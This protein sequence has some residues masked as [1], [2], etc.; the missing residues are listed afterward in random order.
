MVKHENIPIYYEKC[1]NIS[2]PS[3]PFFIDKMSKIQ[4]LSEKVYPKKSEIYKIYLQS[5]ILNK[6]CHDC[7]IKKFYKL[8]NIVWA[9][10]IKHNIETHQSY[11]SE[12]FIKIILNT[13]I[14]NNYII[15]PPIQIHSNQINTFKY[16][17]LH[18][19]KLLI[20]DALMK[21]GSYPRYLIQKNTK[22]SE[23]QLEINSDS[24]GINSNS[25][26]SFKQMDIR[27]I[28]SEHSGV[29]SVKNGIIDNIIV[30]TKTDRID[31]EDNN[32]YLPI[33]T[34][35]LI[36]YEYLFHT[37]PNT[38]RYAG[39]IKEGIIYEFPSVNDIFNFIKYRTEGKAQ[40]SIIVVPEGIY[41]IRPIKYYDK[42]KINLDLFHL[43]R[44]FILKLEK[45]AIKKYKP[46]IHKMSD[47]DT[48]HDTVGSDM[49]YIKM[50]NKFIESANLFIE[51]Y[52]REKKNGEWCLRQINLPYV[53][54]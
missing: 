8:G 46:Y 24:N 48:F 41:I 32:I 18:Y 42:Y 4:K 6:N 22:N 9:N 33:N 2:M 45:M 14:I 31:V 12:Y 26:N 39:R 25:N 52:P 1:T 53:E 19:N 44:K 15:N 34:E 28:Y 17:P 27:Y 21:Q 37:H 49:L 30:S 38:S 35:N 16:I 20:I 5:I 36:N 47:P 11:P 7:N 23:T 54:E 10:N 51:Y 3:Y 40:A 43:L 29:L 13:Y 50:Y